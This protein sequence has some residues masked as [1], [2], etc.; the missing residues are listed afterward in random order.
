MEGLSG[1][2]PTAHPPPGILSAAIYFTLHGASCVFLAFHS[3]SCPG[4][5]AGRSPGCLN[6]L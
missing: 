3:P 6:I 1:E 2:L 4:K 5:G